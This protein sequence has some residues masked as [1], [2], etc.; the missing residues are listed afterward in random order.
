MASQKYAEVQ[1]RR[2]TR[3]LHPKLVCLIVTSSGGKVNV[4]P[5]SWVMPTSADPPLLTVA[6]SPRRYTYELLQSKGEFTVNPVPAGMKSIVEYTGSVSGREVDKVRGAGL[7]LFDAREV[8]APC[9][10]GSL[11]C[12]ECRVWAQYPAG[13]HYLVVGRVAYARV[14]GEA[15]DGETYV[16][17]VAKPL[18]HVGGDRYAVLE[19]F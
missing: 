10:D 1:L 11:A 19:S 8:S 13:D 16:L 2:F 12:I 17:K 18:F 7:S 15:W 14:L 4:M 9:V 3:L 5:A 6:I